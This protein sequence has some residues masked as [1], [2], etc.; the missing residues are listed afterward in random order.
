VDVHLTYTGV[1][2]AHKCVPY[3]R[4]SHE[5]VSHRR[6]SHGHV[7]HRRVPYR[8]V[9]HGRAPHGRA[10]HRR[11]PYGRIPCGFK[12]EVVE[13]AGPADI[14]VIHAIVSNMRHV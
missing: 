6:M 1:H 3:G 7:P 8:C 13:S 5:R 10:P 12:F 11:V 9:S 2:L 4:A 14:S